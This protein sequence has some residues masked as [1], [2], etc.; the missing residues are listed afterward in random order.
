MTVNMKKIQRLKYNEMGFQQYLRMTGADW[1]QI[2]GHLPTK[3]DRSLQ[4][5]TH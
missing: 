2:A 5:T 4:R 1:K 3:R